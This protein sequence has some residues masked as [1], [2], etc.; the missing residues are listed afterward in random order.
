MLEL[1]ACLPFIPGVEGV[2]DDLAG[3]SASR[4]AQLLSSETA[5]FPSLNVQ[6][7]SGPQR[8]LTSAPLSVS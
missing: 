5:S 8:V 3:Q 1:A 2:L 4:P 7:S 6:A